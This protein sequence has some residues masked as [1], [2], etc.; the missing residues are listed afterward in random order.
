M[1]TEITGDLLDL[2]DK[3]EVKIIVHQANCFHTM[4]SGIA[5]FIR[6][7]YPAAYEAD[8]KTAK[9]DIKKLGTYSAASVG[10][11]RIINLY[12]QFKF[13]T[14][15]STGERDTRYDAMYDGLKTLRDKL[16]KVGWKGKIGVPWKMGCNLGGGSWLIVRAILED[17]FAD[18][19]IELVIVRLPDA[20]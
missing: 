3:G 4:G 15:F 13:G 8:C 18:E 17:L 6:E 10:G 2:F 1:I 20:V 14:V 16:N 5:K 19:D 7:R 11:Q 12:S 9:G